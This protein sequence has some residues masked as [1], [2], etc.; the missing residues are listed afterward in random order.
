MTGSCDRMWALVAMKPKTESDQASSN[1]GA[2]TRKSASGRPGSGETNAEIRKVWMWGNV[3]LHKDPAKGETKGEEAS[4]EAIYLRQP[5]YEQRAH[6][7]LPARPDRE[8]VL[9]RPAA[10][11]AG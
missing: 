2:T 7:H 9:T 5:R 11:G 3:A 4:G 6:L 10:A 8:D 1:E